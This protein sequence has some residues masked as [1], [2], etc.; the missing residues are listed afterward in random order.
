MTEQ[1]SVH[2]SFSQPSTE[3][4]K[5]ELGVKVCVHMH[6]FEFG[7]ISAPLWNLQIYVYRVGGMST[8]CET[9]PPT[10]QSCCCVLRHGCTQRRYDNMFAFSVAELMFAL[11]LILIGGPTSWIFE[12]GAEFGSGVHAF[13]HVDV[14]C[15]AFRTECEICTRVV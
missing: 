13:V 3:L 15:I 10:Y 4:F 11:L 6:N 14:Q 12:V 5:G 1:K 2:A 9:S 7:V 8:E